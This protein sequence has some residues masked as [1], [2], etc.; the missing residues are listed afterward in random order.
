MKH[1]LLIFSFLSMFS[2]AHASSQTDFNLQQTVDQYYN[3]V[4]LL[5]FEERPPRSCLPD[6]G[7]C[8]R[9]ACETL[10]RF[11]CDDQVEMD[12][13]R[14]ACR[15]NWDDSCLKASISHLDRFEYDDNEEMVQLINSCRGVYDTE[16]INFSCER[17]GR[18][19]CDQL[20]EIITLNRACA[21]DF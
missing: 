4:E 7:S 16:C 18:F 5:Q 15:G 14:R 17:M 8:F 19:A 10:G 2:F 9:S 1:I 6:A 11:E 12:A 3:L 20:E 13:I 21:G